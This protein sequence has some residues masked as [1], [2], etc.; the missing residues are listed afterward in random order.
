[1]DE[2]SVPNFLANCRPKTT[3]M[4]IFIWIL[5]KDNNLGIYGRTK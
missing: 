4:H 5:S 1:L 2:F 3:D